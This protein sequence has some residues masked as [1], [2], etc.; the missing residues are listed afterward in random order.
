M[1]AIIAACLQL[2]GDNPSAHLVNQRAENAAV[3]RIHPSLIVL[4]GMPGAHDV[5]AILVELHVE[6]DGVFGT[7]AKAVVFRVVSPRVNNLLHFTIY[8]VSKLLRQPVQ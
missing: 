7:T 1:S 6:A 8:F 2:A 3:H 5:V 4:F